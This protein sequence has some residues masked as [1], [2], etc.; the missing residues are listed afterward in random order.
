MLTVAR[1]CADLRT[2][3]MRDVHAVRLSQVVLL[4]NNHDDGTRA[5][6]F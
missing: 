1:H 3:P 5:V 6:E 2:R 4:R